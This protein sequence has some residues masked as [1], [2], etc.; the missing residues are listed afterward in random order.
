[1]DGLRRARLI[2]IGKELLTWKLLT[3]ANDARQARIGDADHMVLTALAAK[4]EL[5]PRPVDIDV[6]CSQR[7]EFIRM[8]LARL[9]DVSDAPRRRSRRHATPVGRRA[10]G[11]ATAHHGRARPSRP[12]AGIGSLFR[13]APAG[14]LAVDRC[15]GPA[16]RPW[17]HATRR[18]EPKRSRRSRLAR[19]M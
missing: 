14:C 17:R 3:A 5:E 4:M 9:L 19:C 11:S 13:R 18:P 10:F 6:L 16:P 2:E 1:F 7:C 8:V 12:V 15:Y